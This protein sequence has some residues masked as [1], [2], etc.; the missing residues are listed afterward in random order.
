MSIAG[1][2][3]TQSMRM[4][5]ER[6]FVVM[7]GWVAGF[8]NKFKATGI[9]SRSYSKSPFSELSLYLGKCRS[10]LWCAE[11][12]SAKQDM[13]KLQ[14]HNIFA[15]HSVVSVVGQENTPITAAADKAA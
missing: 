6:C 2:C 15:A 13:K 4:L 1:H 3:Q 9:L 14:F 11:L 12:M 5:I 7:P 10:S 8:K